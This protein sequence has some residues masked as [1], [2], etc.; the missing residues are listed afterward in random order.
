M[1]SLTIRNEVFPAIEAANLENGFIYFDGS[2]ITNVSVKG[3]T[4]KFTL[5]NG[6]IEV[7]RTVRSS[8][9]IALNWEQVA[10]FM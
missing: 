3:K 1:K 7:D 8:S 5:I 2:E 10:V 4:T 9:L 6:N